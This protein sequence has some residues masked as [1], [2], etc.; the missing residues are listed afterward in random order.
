MGKRT[1]YIV[2]AGSFDGFLSLPQP[3]DLVIAADG[4]YRYL[5]ELGIEPDVLM[6]DFD[7][8]QYVPEHE[9]LLRHPTVKDDSDMALAVAYGQEQGYERFFL[10]GGLGGARMDHTIANIQLLCG[11]SRGGAES[12]LIG[13]GNVM[14][15]LTE[16]R[17]RFGPEAAGMLSVFSL[18]E[19][20]TGVWE[21]GLKYLLNDATL[22]FDRALGL[23]NE[24]AGRTCSVEV[25][26][27]TLLLTWEQ[28]N[29]LPAGRETVREEEKE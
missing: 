21:R 24:F 17:I 26:E 12:Y 2:G 13:Q 16:E 3:G 6:G 15:C 27:G 23:S 28:R 22:V 1:C 20:A 4:G 5:K 29:G 25:Q 9:H 14:T 7:S 18:S 19:R 11:L 8:L 10:Y